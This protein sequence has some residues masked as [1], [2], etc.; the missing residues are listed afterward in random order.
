MKMNRFAISVCCLGLVTTTFAVP[1]VVSNVRAFQRPGTKLVDIYYDVADADGGL[2]EIRVQVSGDGGLTYTIPA[3]T[4]TGAYGSGVSLGLNRHIVWDAGADWGGNYMDTTKVRVTAFDGTTPPAP[5]GMA[6]IPSGQF[7]MG[8][9]FQEGD[10]DELPRHN[11]SL[12]GFFVDSCE[13]TE[14]KWLEVYQWALGKGYSFLSPPSSSSSNTPVRNVTWV[15]A[16]IWCNARSEK[17]SLTR[18]YKRYNSNNGSFY[19]LKSPETYIYSWSYNGYRLPT[20][21]E[22]EKTARGGIVGKRYHNGNE[23]TQSDAKFATVAPTGVAAYAAN[24]F[25]VFDCSGNVSEWCHDVYGANFY[26]SSDGL[27]DPASPP[28]GTGWSTGRDTSSQIVHRGGG[29][30]STVSEVRVANRQSMQGNQSSP[31]IGFRCVRRP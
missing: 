26:G 24:G 3:V 15:D 19:D 8:D 29:Y 27:T 25:G 1:P 12:S 7:Q 9:P 22:W 13:I 20:E 30:S 28:L 31:T 10:V 4:F 23:L 14:S 16:A 18:V 2:Q 5:P 11:V 6:Y 17:E 21:A